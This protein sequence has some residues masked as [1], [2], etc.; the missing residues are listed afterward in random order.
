MS[1]IVRASLAGPSGVVNGHRPQVT[2]GLD[3]EARLT[4]RAMKRL[5]AEQWLKASAL[6][7]AIADTGEV[8]REHYA[9]IFLPSDLVGHALNLWGASTGLIGAG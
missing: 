2:R 8:N 3:L 9:S 7:K 6:A 5:M 4:A 1:R